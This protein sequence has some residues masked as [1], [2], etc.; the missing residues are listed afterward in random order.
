LLQYIFNTYSVHAVYIVVRITGV[1][2]SIEV[3]K[4]DSR[5]DQGMWEALCSGAGTGILQDRPQV[6]LAVS[7]T[8]Y[9]HVRQQCGLL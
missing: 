9:P 5:G 1:H 6:W 8:D 3:T 2:L 4:E 7:T